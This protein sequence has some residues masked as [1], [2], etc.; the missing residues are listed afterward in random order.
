MRLSQADRRWGNRLAALERLPTHRRT[1]LRI[2]MP[3]LLQVPPRAQ[4]Q[5]QAPALAPPLAP[6]QEPVLGDLEADLDQMLI[7]DRPEADLSWA[8]GAPAKRNRFGSRMVRTT[9]TSG[10]L[11]RSLYRLQTFQLEAVFLVQR[12]LAQIRMAGTQRIL[13]PSR[14]SNLDRRISRS[15]LNKDLTFG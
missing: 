6:P 10:I 11:P 12:P 2:P 8:S 7:R 15:A 13:R 1:G 14:L 5:L 4:P 9:I 3:Q